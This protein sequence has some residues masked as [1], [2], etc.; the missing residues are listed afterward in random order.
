MPVINLYSNEKIKFPNGYF[1]RQVLSFKVLDIILI[2]SLRIGPEQT[3]TEMENILRIYF[4]GFSIVRSSIMN[5]SSSNL[6][7]PFERMKSQEITRDN[8]FNKSFSRGA[9]KVRASLATFN[10]TRH[11]STSKENVLLNNS[12][13]SMSIIDK[14]NLSE[15]MNSFDEYLKYSIDQTTNEIVGSSLKNNSTLAKRLSLAGSSE[16]YKFRSQSFGLLSLNNE[17]IFKFF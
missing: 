11:F 6:S 5:N 2:I 1:M 13:G 16:A 17:G 9:F 14:D 8:S 7:R 4:S 3:R 15:E 12:S 10:P